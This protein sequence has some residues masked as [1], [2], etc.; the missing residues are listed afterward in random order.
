MRPDGEHKDRYVLQ[1]TMWSIP[2]MA[3]AIISLIAFRRAS[4]TAHVPGGQALR[5]LFLM[6]FLWSGPQTLET[7]FVQESAKLFLSQLS[8]V[9]IALTPVAWFQFALTYSQRVLK[10]PA[11]LMYCI[12]IVPVIT[13]CLALT[14]TYHH[15]IIN[16]TSHSSFQNLCFKKN[17]LTQVLRK[18]L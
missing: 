13:L 10:M 12:S 2:P 16:L 17:T 1:L 8:Y 4:D 11:M 5:F 14:N 18:I 9:G 15:L 6:I 3:A 7:F